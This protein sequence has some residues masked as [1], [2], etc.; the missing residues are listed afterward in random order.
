M[1]NYKGE[2]ANVDMELG[3][4]YYSTATTAEE[5]EA[6]AEWLAEKE[7]K[8]SRAWNSWMSWLRG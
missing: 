8:R 5:A 1:W 7:E 6:V 2:V 4:Y 3:V